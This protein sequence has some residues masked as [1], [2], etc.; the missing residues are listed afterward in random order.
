MGLNG[1]DISGWQEGI[2]LSAV[3]ADFVIMKATQGTGFVSKDFVRQYQQAK[4][5]GKLVGCYHYAEGDDY[6][7]EANHFLDVVGNRVGEA[8][9]CL[10]WER[11]D[12]PTFGKNDFDWVKGFCDYVFSKTGVK[13][14]VYI[15]K[16]A[17]ERIDGIG[18]YGLWIAQYPDYTPTGYQE[19]P[20]NEGAYACAIRQYS[21]VGQISG[22]DGNLDLDKFYGDESD[23]DKLAGVHIQ[24]SEEDSADENNTDESI[25][26]DGSTLEL[27]VRVKNDEFGVLDER[28]EA[29]GDRYNEVQDF[30]NHIEF[31]SAEEL[32][33]ETK[34]GKYGDGYIRR[35][36]LD[37]RWQE[38]QDIINGVGTDT[39]YYTV[40]SGDTLSDI[41]AKYDTTYQKIAELNNIEN[42]NLIYPGTLLRVR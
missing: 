34:D 37:D 24:D 36:V 40:E 26:I 41:A 9:L 33:K 42:P 25:S 11:Q 16:S 12:N 18:N 20:W 30:I 35:V 15:Q 21:S 4:E 23:W 19:T 17:I 22:Y 27:A 14:L 31:A 8:I 10:D 13:P 38:V 2:D 7:A 3:A 5:N 32:A 1:I 6:V 29:L 39:D 28:R